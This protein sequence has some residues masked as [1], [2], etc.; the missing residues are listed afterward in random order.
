MLAFCGAVVQLPRM[1]EVR[2]LEDAAIVVDSNGD[3][4]ALGAGADITALAA[5][6]GVPPGAVRALGPCEM[7]LPGLVDTHIH[8]PQLPFTGTGTDLPLFE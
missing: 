1:G 4:A 5:A 3:V 2:I 7:L 6:H 8:A